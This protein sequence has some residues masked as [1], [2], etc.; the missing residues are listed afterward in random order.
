MFFRRWPSINK[1]TQLFVLILA[2]ILNVILYNYCSSDFLYQLSYS[3][4]LY[5]QIIHNIRLNSKENFNFVY[6]FGYLSPG[7]MF[8]IYLKC[9]P[10][11]I[12]DVQPDFL[13]VTLYDCIYFI[14][15]ILLYL[16]HKFGSRCLIPN[17]LLKNN[18]EICVICLDVMGKIDWENQ[19]QLLPIIKTTCNHKFHQV[20][21]Q[22]WLL[23]KQLCP[24]CRAPLIELNL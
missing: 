15:V 16:Q 22:S 7:L 20:C 3:L 23:V 1:F 12:Y 2:F 5:P 19:I 14:S 18:D 13:F 24:L 6:L 21:L 10:T 4:I 11:N 8:Q 9:Y 17:W